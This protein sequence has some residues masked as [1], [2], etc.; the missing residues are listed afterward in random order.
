MGAGRP[1]AVVH[2]DVVGD[3]DRGRAAVDRVDDVAAGED[4]VLLALG[5][6]A[7]NRGDLLRAVLE[8]EEGGLVLGAGHELRGERA[9]GRQQEEAHAKE[10]R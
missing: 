8:L 5:A 3:P 10:R 1:F 6:L 9:L 4:A 2:E 7:V